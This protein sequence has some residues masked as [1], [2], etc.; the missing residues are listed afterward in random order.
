MTG[1]QTCALP[2]SHNHPSGDPHPSKADINTTQKLIE[3]GA[4][5]GINV[6]DHVIIGKNN[7]FS[8]V[9]NKKTNFDV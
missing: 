5:L 9:Y 8:I 2:I 1:V 4:L 3:A 6:L 7:C